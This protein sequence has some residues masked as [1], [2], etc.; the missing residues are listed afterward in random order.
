MLLVLVRQPYDIGDRIA[1][2]DAA[3]DTN[4]N[5]STTWFVEGITLFMTTVRNAATNEVA[6]YSNAS[7]ANLRI[8]N[9]ARSPKACVYVYMQFGIE[10]PYEKIKL[11]HSIIDS[12]V[13]ELK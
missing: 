10:V 5:G 8:I 9:A 4:S 6:T 13:K 2:S 1:V 3:T 12:F 11:F 7:L